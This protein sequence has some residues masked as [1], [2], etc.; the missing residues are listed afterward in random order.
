M[1]LI[2]GFCSLLSSLLLVL[3]IAL[4]A[5]GFIDDEGSMSVLAVFIILISAGIN[6]LF[7]LNQPKEYKSM[8]FRYFWA[9]GFILFTYFTVI[10]SP[11]GK[12]IKNTLPESFIAWQHGNLS[13]YKKI[14]TQQQYTEIYK[15][16]SLSDVE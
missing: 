5:F 11:L 3:G 10:L 14:Q 15:Y 13:G 9:N 7:T 2:R 12:M 1:R 4:L 6:I 16:L 8:A